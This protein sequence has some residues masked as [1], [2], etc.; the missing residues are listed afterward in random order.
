[1]SFQRYLEA[2]K[3]VEGRHLDRRVLEDVAGRI[4]EEADIF[5]AGAGVGSMVQ[6]LVEL[7]VVPDRFSY[8]AVDLSPENVRGG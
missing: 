5:E 1:M 6:H 7:D 3:T 2:K 8:T 4:E